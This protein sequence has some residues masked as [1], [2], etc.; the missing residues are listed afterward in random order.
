MS[1]NLISA[2]LPAEDAADVQQN[3]AAAKVSKRGP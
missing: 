1:Q 2:T 3:L